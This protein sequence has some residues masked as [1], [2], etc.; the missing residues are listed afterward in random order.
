M[1]D[2]LIQL[3]EAE[4]QRM[5]R[6]MCPLVDIELTRID[7]YYPVYQLMYRDDD[8]EPC[9][10][11]PYWSAID[12]L[13]DAVLATL[14]EHL[15]KVDNDRL[16]IVMKLTA[17]GITTLHGMGVTTEVIDRLLDIIAA[18]RVGRI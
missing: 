9:F 6:V 7:K 17:A 5:L 11:L 18:A 2:W 3:Q 13:P 8:G 12:L 4:A 16:E 10:L 15:C 14:V 1:H